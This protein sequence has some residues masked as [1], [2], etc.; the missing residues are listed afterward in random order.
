[1]MYMAAVCETVGACAY[2]LVPSILGRVALLLAY[3]HRLAASRSRVT[4]RKLLRLI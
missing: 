3:R 4:G 1:M 2:V